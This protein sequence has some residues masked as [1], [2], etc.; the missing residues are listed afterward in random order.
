MWELGTA[1]R[2]MSA[3]YKVMNLQTYI[4][5]YNHKHSARRVTK[6]RL[7]KLKVT[8]IRIYENKF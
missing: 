1:V 8:E 6:R 2:K 4:N 7:F 5:V 3:D